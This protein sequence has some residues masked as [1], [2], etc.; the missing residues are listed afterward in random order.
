MLCI[1]YLRMTVKHD[2]R[3]NH[4]SSKCSY[5][6]PEAVFPRLEIRH[7]YFKD[8]HYNV[9]EVQLRLFNSLFIILALVIQ[10]PCILT[11]PSICVWRHTLMSSTLPS[12][13]SSH[14]A[15]PVELSRLITETNMVDSPLRVQLPSLCVRES[16]R[17]GGRT[18]GRE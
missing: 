16:E 4:A 17:D 3:Y 15:A 8:L 13:G 5:H 6:Q 18:R 1:F 12:P 14:P 11:R 10:A 9:V 7:T 2:Q